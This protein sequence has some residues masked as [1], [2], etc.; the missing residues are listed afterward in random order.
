MKLPTAFASFAVS[1]R[2]SSVDAEEGVESREQALKRGGLMERIGP[3]IF[4]HE[5]G[6]TPVV[7]GRWHGPMRSRIRIEGKRDRFKFISPDGPASAVHLHSPYLRLP[8]GVYPAIGG[9]CRLTYACYHTSAVS[10]WNPAAM[11]LSPQ[12]LRMPS[13]SPV[14][15]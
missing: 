9:A 5:E 12:G 4:R 10:S 11:E 3:V 1:P 7:S 14:L 6:G 8:P 13:K 15:S 2:L